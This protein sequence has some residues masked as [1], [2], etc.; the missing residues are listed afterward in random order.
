MGKH[1]HYERFLVPFRAALGLPP[2]EGIAAPESPP[3]AGAASGFPPTDLPP[4]QF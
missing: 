4:A 1:A 3:A 2:A